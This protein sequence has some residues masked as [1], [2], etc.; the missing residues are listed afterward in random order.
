MIRHRRSAIPLDRY[1]TMPRLLR[2]CRRRGQH[3]LAEGPT[4]RWRLP[5][6]PSELACSPVH[7]SRSPV[8]QRRPFVQPRGSGQVCAEQVHHRVVVVPQPRRKTNASGTLT[9]AQT[10]LP[11]AAVDSPP[12]PHR[13]FVATVHKK[14]G[15][16]SRA[17]RR[18]LPTTS[19]NRQRRHRS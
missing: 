6:A 3:I 2:V 14:Y 4:I 15:K 19:S 5:R 1:R 17:L 12:Q 13:E 9:N 16:K 18:L 11:I 10:P 8:D 7:R